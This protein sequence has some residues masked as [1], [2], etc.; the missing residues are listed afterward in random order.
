[1]L[2]RLESG[3]DGPQSRGGNVARNDDKCRMSVVRMRSRSRRFEQFGSPALLAHAP[4][5]LG[6]QLARWL[7]RGFQLPP[8]EQ[9]SPPASAPWAFTSEELTHAEVATDAW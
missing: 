1:M 2:R 3:L 7:A 8:I 5:R 6:S 4:D 9:D